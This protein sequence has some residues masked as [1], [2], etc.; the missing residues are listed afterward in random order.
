MG[1][2]Q[3]FDIFFTNNK[4]VYGPGESVG[5]VVRIRTSSALQYKGT[6]GVLLPRG[7]P[8]AAREH[9]S[10]RGKFWLVTVR[11]GNAALWKFLLKRGASPPERAV[12]SRG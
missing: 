12:P 2:L 9:H 11:M 5:G 4:V 6:E 8:L 7:L 10:V 1:K 3:E